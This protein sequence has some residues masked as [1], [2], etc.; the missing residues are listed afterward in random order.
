[1]TQ[2][3]LVIDL[4]VCVGCHACVTSCKEWNTSGTAGYM[5]DMNPFGQDPTGTFFNRVF[6]NRNF[7]K[8]LWI[9]DHITLCALTII[10]EIKTMEIIMEL[11]MV[12]RIMA[13]IMEKKMVTIIR[14]I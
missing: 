13:I 14:A 7:F 5:A 12:I 6:R 1:M 3:A 4:N 10:V 11:L 2:L 9:F 8:R